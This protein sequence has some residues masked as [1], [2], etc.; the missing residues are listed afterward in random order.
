MIMDITYRKFGDY[1]LPNIDLGLKG[2][3]QI[4]RYGNMRRDYLRQEKKPIYTSLILEGSL[5]S[6]LLEIQNL[7]EETMDRIIEEMKISEGVTEELKAS[8]QLL[9]VQRMNNIRSRAEEIVVQ[10]IIRS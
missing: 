8:N 3:D 10:E 5:I 9:W 6:H 7:A 4:S 1:L 2:A